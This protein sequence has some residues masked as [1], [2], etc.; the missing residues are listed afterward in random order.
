V[1]LTL[2]DPNQD[3]KDNSVRAFYHSG[4]GQGQ[5]LIILMQSIIFYEDLDKA[6]EGLSKSRKKEKKKASMIEL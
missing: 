1:L 6:D 3:E 4:Y 2:L 5:K